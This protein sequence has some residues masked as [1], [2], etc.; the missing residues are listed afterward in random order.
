[1]PARRRGVK[2]VGEVQAAASRYH[3]DLL[4]DGGLVDRRSALQRLKHHIEHGTALIAHAHKNDPHSAVFVIAPDWI[5]DR[6]FAEWRT[7]S[8]NTLIRIARD[9]EHLTAEGLAVPK[10]PGSAGWTRRRGGNP[11]GGRGWT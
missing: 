3:G 8:L 2:K 9:N 7:D 4:A 1:M 11:P 10:A 6:E 5:E